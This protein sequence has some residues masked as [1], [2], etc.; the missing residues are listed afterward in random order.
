M[1]SS[2]L[3]TT[4]LAETTNNSQTTATQSAEQESGRHGHG[5]M[6]KVAEPENAISKDK[7][8]EAALKDAGISS[9]KVDKIRSFVIKLDD[10]TVVYRVSFKSGEKYYTYKINALTGNVAD[11]KE[12]TADE[13]EA[14]KKEH[15]KNGAHKGD[16]TENTTTSDN[17]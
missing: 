10:G 15:G 17:S 9:D 3:G 2:V 1:S 7:A 6:E 5:K 4:A 14:S 16:K 8:K 13:H 11:K 12:Q